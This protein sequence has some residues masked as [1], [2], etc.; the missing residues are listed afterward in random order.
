MVAVERWGSLECV[1]EGDAV[2]ILSDLVEFAE[3]NWARACTEYSDMTIFSGR[4]PEVKL[5]ERR[6]TAKESTKTAFDPRS[7]GSGKDAKLCFECGSPD[8]RARDC[9]EVKGRGKGKGKGKG[10][11]QYQGSWQS[12]WNQDGEVP[13][14]QVHGTGATLGDPLGRVVIFLQLVV[15]IQ[16]RL[17]EPLRSHTER[18]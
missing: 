7:K 1:P 8:H 16:G 17:V 11:S 4:F 2:Q 6:S 15:F 14:A 12:S 9:P 13:G 3:R 5:T 18:D 10:K